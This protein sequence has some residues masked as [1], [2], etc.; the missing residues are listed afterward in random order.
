MSNTPRGPP[1]E[2][3]IFRCCC[4]KTHVCSLLKTLQSYRTSCVY[5]SEEDTRQTI[6]RVSMLMCPAPA[7]SM[8]LPASQVDQRWC[9]AIVGWVSL[10]GL[11]LR[12]VVLL[13]I[14]VNAQRPSSLQILESDVQVVAKHE[15]L[16]HSLRHPLNG[17]EQ[18]LP[19]R[20]AVLEALR[21]ARRLRPQAFP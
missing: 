18:S 10:T 14:L 13:L 1:D 7:P 9:L 2:K 11:R 16:I 6:A 20:V 8:A 3:R 15:I 12:R 17:F 4:R 5:R 19:S 21:R